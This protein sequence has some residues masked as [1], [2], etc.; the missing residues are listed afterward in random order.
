ML[1]GQEEALLGARAVASTMALQAGVVVDLGGGSLQI[2]T[3][4]GGEA[5]AA[6]SLPLGAV[7][8]TARFLR[9]DPPTAGEVSALRREVRDLAG[10]LIPPASEG[11]L[12]VGLGGTVRA[13]ARIHRAGAGGVQRIHAMCLGREAVAT[14]AGRLASLPRRRRRTVEGLRAERVDIIVAGALIVEEL[15]AI[16]GYDRLVVCAHGVR[17]GVLA[18]ETF[19]SA[20]ASASLA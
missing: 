13:L 4:R 3:V 2:T 7:R 17:H 8:V 16:G 19:G 5:H 12:L 6:V 11:G 18:D 20:R 10:G 1:S 15:M 14:I 9:H